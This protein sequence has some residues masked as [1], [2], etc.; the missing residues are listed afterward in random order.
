MM[1]MWFSDVHTPNVKLSIRVDEQLFSAN[2]ELQR[3]DV[4][5]SREFGKILVVDG[6]LALTERM[7]SYTMK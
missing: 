2:S 1:E 4:L 7:N 5:S 6:D 3:L